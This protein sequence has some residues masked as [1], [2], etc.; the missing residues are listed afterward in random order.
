M[1]AAK[2]GTNWFAVVIATI[3]VVAIV[4]VGALVVFL[5]NRAT[6]PGAAP[7]GAIINSETGAI[8]FGD[9]P[10]TIAVYL[11]FMCPACGSFEAQY[12][13]LLAEAAGD[14]TITLEVHPI[15]IQD[16]LSQGT[17][18]S[19][20]AASAMYCVASEAPEAGLDFQLQ[21]FANQPA[22]GTTGLSDEQIIAIAEQTGG[23]A[24]ADCISDGTYKK[25]VRDRT[26]ETPRVRRGS[27]RPP[28]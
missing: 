9:G 6:A 18:F 7:E 11:D 16:H 12:G 14:D 20:R 3:T 23:G 15:A 24:A 26:P 2:G 19:S 28:S 10:D 25:F 5:N 27:R 22:Q 4:G 17:E 13:D 21:M 1:A 8:S